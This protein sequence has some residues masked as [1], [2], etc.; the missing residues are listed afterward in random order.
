MVKK[1][2][3]GI[4]FIKY[5]SGIWQCAL[6]ALLFF[7]MG[8]F[9]FVI[10]MN[11]PAFLP[12]VYLAVS[13]MYL[14][15]L[16]NTLH[17]SSLVRSSPKGKALQTSIPAIVGTVAL[18]MT[19]G[20]TVVVELLLLKNGLTR[21]EDVVSA[22]VIAGLFEMLVLGYCGMAFKWFFVS[23]FLFLMFAFFLL[24]I[25][26]LFNELVAPHIPLWGAVIIG[27]LEI[28][29]GGCLQFML[30]LMV[31]RDPSSKAAQMAQLRKYM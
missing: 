3:F 25:Q 21:I 22:L 15:Q 27:A 26:Y 11:K 28:A 24:P 10:N 2:K 19:Y 20:L 1:F 30:S 7:V 12:P 18:L 16:L 5:C 8:V 9:F 31:Y 17:T 23:L 6:F 14:I 13:V 29:L 4:Q